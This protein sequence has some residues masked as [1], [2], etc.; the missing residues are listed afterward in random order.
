MKTTYGNW[1][2]DTK[3]EVVGLDDKE[4]YTLEGWDGRAFQSCRK[5]KSDLSSK[6]WCTDG[7]TRF[8]FYSH[9][10]PGTY[11]LTPVYEMDGWYQYISGYKVEAI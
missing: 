9:E 7:K 11:R 2:M 3:V 8:F 1:W 4:A 10:E 5:L 6:R